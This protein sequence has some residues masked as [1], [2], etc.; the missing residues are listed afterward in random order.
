MRY[1]YVNNRE[2]HF[3]GVNHINELSISVG[4]N[5]GILAIVHVFLMTFLDFKD[6]NFWNSTEVIKGTKMNRYIN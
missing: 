3:I 2:F 1:I 4:S 5:I 6:L